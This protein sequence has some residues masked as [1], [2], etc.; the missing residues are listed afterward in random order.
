MEKVIG[1]IN[2]SLITNRFPIIIDKYV[3]AEI[4]YEDKEYLIVKQSDIL[5]IIE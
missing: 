5:A 1:M 4:K 2:K 3:G